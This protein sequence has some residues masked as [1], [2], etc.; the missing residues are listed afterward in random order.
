VKKTLA[1]LRLMLKEL[2]R[3]VDP[4]VKGNGQQK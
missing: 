3:A 1:Y 2:G 4:L